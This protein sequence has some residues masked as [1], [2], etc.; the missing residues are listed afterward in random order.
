MLARRTFTA[1]NINFLRPALR[2]SGPDME[3]RSCMGP[4]RMNG[5]LPRTRTPPLVALLCLLHSV[6]THLSIHPSVITPFCASKAVSRALYK[7]ERRPH[8]WREFEVRSNRVM[9]WITGPDK[10]ELL[11]GS[12]AVK[13]YRSLCTQPPALACFCAESD[14]GFPGAQQSAGRTPP[15]LNLTYACSTSP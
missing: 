1:Y 14:N 15:L 3:C 10:P 13:P 11:V 2:S 9:E 5:I 8:P 7:I 12:T 4:Q 6:S